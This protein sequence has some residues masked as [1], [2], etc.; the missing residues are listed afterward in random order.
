MTKRKL[1]LFVQDLVYGQ[2]REAGVLMWRG[3]PLDDYVNQCYGNHLDTATKGY[4]IP[5]LRI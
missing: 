4:A 2:Y 5:V 3:Y 1:F